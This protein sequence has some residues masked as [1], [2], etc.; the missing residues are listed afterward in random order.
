MW[1]KQHEKGTWILIFCSNATDE[2]GRSTLEVPVSS[3]SRTSHRKS[4]PSKLSK[5]TSDKLGTKIIVSIV[6]IFYVSPD[7]ILQFYEL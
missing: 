6:F 3:H 5:F 1:F 4:S 7:Q 2:K